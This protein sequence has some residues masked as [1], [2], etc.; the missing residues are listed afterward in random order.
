MKR[1]MRTSTRLLAAER[2]GKKQ[3]LP[4]ITVTVSTARLAFNVGM[5]RR[6]ARTLSISCKSWE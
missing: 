4:H 3:L 6:L 2:C 1:S 5:G